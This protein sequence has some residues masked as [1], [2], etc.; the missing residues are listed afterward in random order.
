LPFPLVGRVLFHVGNN[1]PGERSAASHRHFFA[2]ESA[3]R[4]SHR[5]LVFFPIC[6]L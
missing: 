5:A 1:V 2:Q 4:I 6:L 3:L